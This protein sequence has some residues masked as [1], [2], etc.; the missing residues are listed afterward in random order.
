M[1]KLERQIRDAISSGRWNMSSHADERCDE[2][3]VEDWQLIEGFN[4]GRTVAIDPHA[5]PNPKILRE[6]TL[7]S[8]ET[9][10]VVWSYQHELCIAKLVTVYFEDQ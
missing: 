2:R 1:T 10:V 5:H 4:A 9:V 7:A 3:G 6:Q 8:G